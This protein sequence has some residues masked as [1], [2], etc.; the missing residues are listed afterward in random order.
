MRIYINEDKNEYLANFYD[1]RKTFN[2]E[3]RE[4]VK[5]ILEDVRTSGD[6]AVRKYTR[7]FDNVVL[8][9]FEV[10]DEEI[11][12]AKIDEDLKVALQ[13]AK[14]NI[15]TFHQRELEKSW[16]IERE[17]GSRF[18]I[19]VY[20]I[21][22]VGVYVPGGSAPLPSSVLMNIIPAK[23]AGVKEI[24]MCTP[25][26]KDGSVSPVILKAAKMAGADRIYKI[27]GAQAIAAMAYGTE[28]V[29]KV[30]KI[31]GPG[32]AYVACAKNLV[33][34]DV[35]ID[36]IAGPS[37]I[38]IVAD[39]TANCDYI[40]ADLLSQAEHDAMA[41]S[42][43]VTTSMYVAEKVREK[44]SERLKSLERNAIAKKSI[45]NNGAIIV[46]DNINEA[47]ALSNAI[48][49]E[50][51]ELMLNDKILTDELIDKF[52]NAGAIFV[53]EY[54]PE[55]MGDYFCGSNHVL[56][57]GGTAAFSSPLGVWDFVKRTSI[58]NYTKEGFFKDC[59]H[60]YNMAMA[61]GLTA[62]AKSVKARCEDEQV[63]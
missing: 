57:T 45:E 6:E 16:N 43:L 32:N 20:S 21:Q 49:P 26:L 40:A 63:F 10:T 30:F 17:D 5:K 44:V 48:A 34:G 61:E 8:D 58:V 23:V 15:F 38:L 31:T 2:E 59:R 14:E 46:V 1:R 25:P 27:G 47:A 28:S 55:P 3:I 50:H 41:A 62:H 60:A 53:G 4:K 51:L 54:S 9:S 24:I 37:E 19:R 29:P 13:K 39:E 52:Y 12:R 42:I 35:G 22:K 33:F 18:G 56:P 11:E 36:M 7:M